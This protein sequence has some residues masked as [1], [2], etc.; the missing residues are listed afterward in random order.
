MESEI[1]ETRVRLE[2]AALR[3]EGHL[4]LGQYD[5]A[6]AALAEQQRL[7]RDLED[8]VQGAVAGAVVERE[9]EWV[10]ASAASGGGTDER[11]L[12]SGRTWVT[13]ALRVLPAAAGTALVAAAAFVAPPFVERADDGAGSATAR[14]SASSTFDV[15][16]GTGTHEVGPV[17]SPASARTGDDPDPA[18][19]RVDA[20]PDVRRVP[21]P[22]DP[23]TDV[24]GA[25]GAA[26]D[27]AVAGVPGL[28]AAG[29]TVEE[30]A[31][32]APA[33]ADPGPSLDQPGPDESGAADAA[34][35][36]ATDG[37][38]GSGDESRASRGG[39][40][41][42]AARSS[43][44]ASSDGRTTRDGAR[45]ERSGDAAGDHDGG[46]TAPGGARHADDGHEPGSDD[47]EPDRP[48]TDGLAPAVDTGDG[49][50]ARPDERGA[51]VD[52]LTSG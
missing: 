4:A 3:S 41:R 26:L 45:Q 46:S 9:A 35:R 5:R 48:G 14:R 13:A 12:R 10:M 28:G 34:P 32:A 49:A 33:A 23:V 7:V 24:A 8:R 21:A 36:S 25:T 11:V 16:H 29:Q 15:Q 43:D 44:G 37:V 31:A 38:D 40:E 18:A 2:E 47:A 50:V 52:E 19:E 22:L 17:R 42:E 1:A 39:D 51:D 27:V 20:T 30:A 6:A